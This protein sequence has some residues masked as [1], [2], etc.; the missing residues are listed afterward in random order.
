VVNTANMIIILLLVSIKTNAQKQYN[1]LD[2]KADVSLNTYLAQQMH[3]QYDLRRA[4]FN[5]AMKSKR[6]NINLY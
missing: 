1:V 6:A 2:W 5:N 4:D 3:Q